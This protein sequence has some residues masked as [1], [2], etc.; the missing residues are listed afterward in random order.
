MMSDGQPA[1]EWLPPSLKLWRDEPGGKPAFELL[2]RGRPTFQLLP[3]SLKLWRDES[4]WH[5]GRRYKGA[6]RSVHHGEFVF[7]ESV[8]L[9][10]L[11]SPRRDLSVPRRKIEDAIASLLPTQLIRIGH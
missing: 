1:F 4:A 10:I 9:V 5:A 2:R 7:R 11:R 3:P 8:N 6:R